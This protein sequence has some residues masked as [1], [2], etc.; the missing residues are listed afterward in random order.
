MT[1]ATRL[2]PHAA[3]PIPVK[4]A[5][6]KLGNNIRDCRRKRRIQVALLSER[7]HICRAT[8]H[9][10]EQGHPGVALGIYARVI[11]SLG[12]IDRLSDLVDPG[13]DILGM[14]LD[15]DRL[16]KRIRISNKPYAR[17]SKSK[18]P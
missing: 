12:M 13:K 4:R 15:S 5:L 3:L 6:R 16:P 8:L 10:V 7:A 11:F 2:S 18:N 1:S 9:K 17:P 14:E